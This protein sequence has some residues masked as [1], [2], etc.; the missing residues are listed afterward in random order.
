M[1]P[2]LLVSTIACGLGMT[3]YAS[4]LPS[5][6]TASVVVGFQPRPEANVNADVIR[7]VLPRYVAYLTSPSTEQAVQR[8]IGE[9]PGSVTAAVNAEVAA[10]TANLTVK[11]TR[12]R[13]EQAAVAA[14]AF[15]G[16]AVQYNLQDRLLV[17]QAVAPALP[18]DQA[19]GPRRKQFTAAGLLAGLALGAAL[20]VL[21]DRTR[22]RGAWRR[23]AGAVPRPEAPVDSG[24]G[25]GGHRPHAPG[26]LP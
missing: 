4:T 20:A 19:S 26:P 8:T 22:A 16:A 13:P 12:Q 21:L 14:N 15:A 17:G 18:P 11:A 1:W 6:Y 7:V 23:R 9:R 2:L 25:V 10:E 3:Y 5:E 24:R